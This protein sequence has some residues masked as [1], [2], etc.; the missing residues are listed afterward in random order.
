M[1]KSST[2][3][4]GS[5]Q[6]PQL[7]WVTWNHTRE[8]E[9]LPTTGSVPKLFFWS[10]TPSP[11]AACPRGLL[12]GLQISLQWENFVP[13][14]IQSESLLKE[15]LIQAEQYILHSPL[16]DIPV[17]LLE[18]LP[19]QIGSFWISSRATHCSINT[20]QVSTHPEGW[21][22]VLRQ[23]LQPAFV[24]SNEYSAD[25][26]RVFVPTASPGITR[27]HEMGAHWPSGCFKLWPAPE[28]KHVSKKYDLLGRLKMKKNKMHHLSLTVVPKPTH[29]SLPPCHW[30]MNQMPHPL[31]RHTHVSH[32][33]RFSF[34]HISSV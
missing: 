26:E 24:S 8:E 5:P 19:A 20:L 6:H 33:H 31:D 27:W 23:L 30:F 18:M 9:I 32:W 11:V 10:Q 3:V 21:D 1:G 22:T 29:L 28:R 2:Q 25:P 15:Q 17:S 13:L 4:W 14:Q 34:P 7:Q 12:H 16:Q